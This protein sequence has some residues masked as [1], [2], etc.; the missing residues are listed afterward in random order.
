M[1]TNNNFNPQDKNE[2]EIDLSELF[3]VLWN[4][5]W[6]VVVITTT[7]S[8]AAV[9]YSLSIP[10]VYQSRAILS[11]VGD[12]GGGGLSQVCLLYT[13]PSPRDVG[14]SRMPSSA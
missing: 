13:S 4:G 14:I 6:L 2:R 7:F 9:I 12:S 10:N 3:S 11:P 8:I 5:K 1:E